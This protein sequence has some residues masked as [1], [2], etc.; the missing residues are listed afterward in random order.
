MVSQTTAHAISIWR[1][2][3]PAHFPYSAMAT[4]STMS[5]TAGRFGVKVAEVSMAR[6]AT[7]HG[8]CQTDGCL[9]AVARTGLCWMH[10][11]QVQRHGMTREA[12]LAEMLD[13]IAKLGQVDTDED[14]DAEFEAQYRRLQHALLVVAGKHRL[15]R[16]FLRHS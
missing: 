6:R 5:T 9:R 15:P 2:L 8:H 12:A 3:R 4:V 10:F 1:P 11:K 7:G 13:A 16:A 14:S